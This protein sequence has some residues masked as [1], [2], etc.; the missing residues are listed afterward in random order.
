MKTAS[1]VIYTVRTKIQADHVEEFNEWQNTEH[2][3]WIFRV[4]GY[5]S[6]Q[7]FHNLEN[8]YIYMNLWEID[9]ISSHDSPEKMSMSKTPWGQRMLR[10]R[11]LRVSFY[12][13]VEAVNLGEPGENNYS[14]I[15]YLTWD[16][17]EGNKKA[18]HNWVQEE[19]FPQFTKQDNV[20][21]IRYFKVLRG[22]WEHL[23]VIYLREEDEHI[24]QTIQ[25]VCQEISMRAG[26][27]E[28]ETYQPMGPVIYKF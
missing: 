10:F 2:V 11:E 22:E 18:R 21:G 23:L 17:I 7:R 14:K 3:P 8:P 28:M 19:L 25:D 26:R 15:V 24:R 13:Q 20:D 5:L 9:S 1:N 16:D 6:N 4:S 27:F 12:Q